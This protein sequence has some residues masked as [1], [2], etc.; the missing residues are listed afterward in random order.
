MRCFR[1]QPQRGPARTPEIGMALEKMAT[2][3]TRCFSVYQN[4]RYRMTP[5][6]KPDSTAPSRKRRMQKLVAP[7]ANMV[8]AET[9]PHTIMMGPSK[10]RAP[11]LRSAMLL[12]TWKNK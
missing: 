5:G 3:R 11:T 7:V 12:G 6:K 2:I 10:R 8:A 9:S 1:I 4:V